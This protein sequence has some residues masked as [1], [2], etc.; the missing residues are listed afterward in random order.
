MSWHGSHGPQGA[1]PRLVMAGWL[2]MGSLMKNDPMGVEP[3]IGR[4][5]PPK[6][7]VYFVV[8]T[9]LKFHGFGGKPIIFWKHPHGGSLKAPFCFLNVPTVHEWLIW[10]VNSMVNISLSWMGFS[11]CVQ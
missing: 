9:L 5:D 8:P 2:V 1:K 3:N 6:W 10:M 7:M 11:I 4:F